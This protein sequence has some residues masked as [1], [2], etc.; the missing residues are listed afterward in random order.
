[1]KAAPAACP[2]AAARKQGRFR[3]AAANR[4]RLWAGTTGSRP[5]DGRRTPQAA[6]A[7]RE[8]TTDLGTSR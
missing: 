1:M 8:A 2:P 4:R 5:G 6:I 3:A 7:G